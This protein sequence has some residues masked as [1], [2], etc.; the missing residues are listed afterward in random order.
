GGVVMERVVGWWVDQGA[1]VNLHARRDWTPLAV[2][3]LA[4]RPGD[5]DPAPKINS[6]TQ[7]LRSRGARRTARWAVLNEDA[8]WLRARHAEGCVENPLESGDGGLA[9]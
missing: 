8:E 3:G 1:D 6:I 2:V 4:V 5:S 7:L 9:L